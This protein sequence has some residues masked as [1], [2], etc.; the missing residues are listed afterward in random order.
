MKGFDHDNYQGRWVNDVDDRLAR[1][2]EGGYEF[3]NKD[4]A[5]MTDPTM[6]ATTKLDSR[7]KKPVG[8]GV[9]AYLMKLPKDLWLADQADKE[10]EIKEI[11]RAMKTPRTNNA[12]YGKVDLSVANTPFKS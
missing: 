2:L 12:D 11:D 9:T 1:F 7:V 6:D 5:M 8:R 10:R 3:V 4:G